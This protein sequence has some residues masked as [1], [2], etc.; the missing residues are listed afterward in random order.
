M[1]Q[2]HPQMD[3]VE[4]S[5]SNQLAALPSNQTPILEIAQLDGLEVLSISKEIKQFSS[6]IVTLKNANRL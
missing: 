6:K 4:P 5:I 2:G 1:Q 3:M